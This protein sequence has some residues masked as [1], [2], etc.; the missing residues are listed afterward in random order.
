MPELC[1]FYGIVIQMSYGNHPPPHF[2]AKYGGHETVEDIDNLTVSDG[3]LPPRANGLVIE[4][5]SQHRN[6]RREA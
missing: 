4:W 1:R 2:H 6:E 5:A 3:D